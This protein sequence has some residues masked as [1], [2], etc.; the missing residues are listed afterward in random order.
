MRFIPKIM[1]FK[2]GNIVRFPNIF[3]AGQIAS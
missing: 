2:S 1:R 3:A